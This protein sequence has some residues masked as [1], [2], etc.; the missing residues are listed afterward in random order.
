MSVVSKKPERV[1]GNVSVRHFVRDPVSKTV[2]IAQGDNTVQRKHV[3]EHPDGVPP[4]RMP[5]QFDII[6]QLVGSR[7]SGITI[8]IPEIWQVLHRTTST[9]S[10]LTHLPATGALA[11]TTFG[12]DRPPTVILSDPEID[13]AYIGQQFTPQ[14]CQTIWGAAARPTS[15]DQSP[16]RPTTVAAEHTEHLAVAASN[17]MYLFTRAQ[18]GTWDIKTGLS[19]LGTDVLAVDWISHSTVALGCR[20]GKIRLY[21]TRSGGSSHILTHPFAISKVKRAD[22]PTRL[23]VSGLQDTMFLY[24]IRSPRPSKGNPNQHY[25]N[26]YLDSIYPTGLTSKK[27]R[28]ISH[29]ARTNWSQPILTFAHANTDDLELDIDVHPRLGLVAAAQNPDDEVAIRVSNLWT[30]KT[31]KEF[32]REKGSGSG[33]ERMRSLEFMDEEDGGVE[34]WACWRGG[35][36]KFGWEGGDMERERVRKLLKGSAE[37]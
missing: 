20:D 16:G 12:A 30:G 34:L 19:S 9:I 14:N 26:S 8:S 31:V 4:W 25:T 5:T 29:T 7:T 32:K 35:V 18:N 24:D 6:D 37:G 23:I 2:Y 15:F 17:A 1:V 21:D 3:G 13:G 11:I 22:D 10:S 27:R 33:S 28:K 36:A